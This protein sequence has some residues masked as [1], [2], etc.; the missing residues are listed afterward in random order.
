MGQ[1]DGDLV[2]AARAGDRAAYGA[3]YERHATPIHDFVLRLTRSRADAADVTQDV[4]ITALERLG[5]L[6]DPERFRSWVF[7]IAHRRALDGL[8]A[9]NRTRPTDDEHTLTVVDPDR[10]ADPGRQAEAEEVAALVWDVAASLDARTYTLLDLNVR[11]DLGASEIADVLGVT[12]NA[13]SVQLHRMRATVEA[14]MLTYLLARRHRRDCDDLDAILHGTGGLDATLRR[15]VEAHIGDCETCARHRRALVAPMQAF[16][17]LAAVEAPPEV[18]AAV[19]EAADAHF[20]EGASDGPSGSRRLRRAAVVA[21]AVL[22]LVVAGAGTVGLVQRGDGDRGAPD[23]LSGTLSP[24]TPSTAAEDDAGALDGTA[25]ATV[26]DD[27]RT[28]S[29]GDSEGPIQESNPASAAP[30]PPTPAPSPAP[31]PTPSPSPAPTPTPSPSATPSATP[32][33]PPATPPSV[34]VLAPADGSTACPGTV[35]RFRGEAVDAEGDVLDGTALAWSSDQQGQL[36]SGAQLDVALTASGPHVVTLTATDADG[37]AATDD[38]GVQVLAPDDP[39]CFSARI[40]RPADGSRHQPSTRD[41][42]GWVT[43]VGVA[44]QARHAATTDLTYTWHVDGAAVGT[45]VQTT[46]RLRPDCAG[47]QT[48]VLRLDV[49]DPDGTIVSDTVTIVLDPPPTGC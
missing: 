2:L 40:E 23:T 48:R 12:P 17:A 31:T 9:G 20:G 42:Q 21:G 6:R 34:A 16:A 43:E 41:G 45:G 11:R 25:S 32:T 24:T 5:Q 38:V 8:S 13:A 1:S 18:A 4:F 26:A 3:L 30:D 15:E 14:A 35:V 19:G 37:T 33:R 7:Q 29:T 47:P 22:V 27:H 10:L 36:G 49:R 39:T 46:L 44:G 28:A